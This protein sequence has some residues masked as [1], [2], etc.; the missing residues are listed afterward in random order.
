[1][2]DQI[3]Q[4]LKEFPILLD[5]SQCVPHKHEILICG[6]Y[7]QRVCYSYHTL[8][9]EYKLI[10]EYPSDA[11]L[12]GHC[13][14]KLVNKDNNNKDSNSITL[15]SF[16]GSNFRKRHTLVMEYV[17][18]WGNV[19]NELNKYNQWVPFT[20]EHNLPII[21]GKYEG[22]N[23]HGARAVIDE[24]TI[25]CYLSLIIQAILACLI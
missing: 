23:Y 2:S 4:N 1:M 16:G 9:N 5:E 10:C 3:F 7:N 11:E 8:K 25:I 22:H 15:L 20:D 19:S 21:I 18:V 17:S 12:N 6:G 24:V 13:V 14:V